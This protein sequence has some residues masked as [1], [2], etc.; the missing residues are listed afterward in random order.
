MEPAAWGTPSPTPGSHRPSPRLRA[1]SI[2][3]G[4]WG[5]KAGPGFRTVGAEVS[6]G[7][8]EGQ[9]WALTQSWNWSQA[10][11]GVTVLPNVTQLL[12]G[13]HGCIVPST[14]CAPRAGLSDVH[15]PL[16]LLLTAVLWTGVCS[17]P[18]LQVRKL[19]CTGRARLWPWLPDSEAHTLHSYAL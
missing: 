19:G 17:V 2:K 10:G 11:G 16:S 13:R 1:W 4:A 7:Q 5:T 8:W 18:I 12:S 3:P 9:G 15:G 14:C 6:A